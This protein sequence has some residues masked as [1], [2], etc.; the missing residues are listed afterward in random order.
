MS[1][2]LS[3]EEEMNEMLNEIKQKKEPL[4]I[5][6]KNIKTTEKEFAVCEAS[7][8][9]RPNLEKLFKALQ[10]IQPTSTESERAFSGCGL[11]VTI[12]RSRLK[13]STINNLCF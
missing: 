9:R 1:K 7:R 3:V 2:T 5:S 6:S 10:N 8:K 12:M 11:F 13:S 4:P